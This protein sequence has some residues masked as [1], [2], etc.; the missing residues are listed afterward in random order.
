MDFLCMVVWLFAEFVQE[1]PRSRKM[2]MRIGSGIPISQS[3]SKET[4]PL[5]DFL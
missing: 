1:Q 3:K 2:M 5:M 4:F